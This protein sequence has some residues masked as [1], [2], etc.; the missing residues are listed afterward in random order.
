[1]FTRRL[2]TKNTIRT[3]SSRKLAGSDNPIHRAAENIGEMKQTSPENPSI[4][5]SA[6]AIGKQFNGN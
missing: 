5:S 6:G 3:M 4:F 1:M 2:I